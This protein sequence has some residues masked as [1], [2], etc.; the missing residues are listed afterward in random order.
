MPY[1]CRICIIRHATEILEELGLN[2]DE[3]IENIKIQ[4]KNIST[5]KCPECGKILYNTNGCVQCNNC[6]W[7]KCN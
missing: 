2:E 5:N 7:S 1:G 4:T 6:G 3:E